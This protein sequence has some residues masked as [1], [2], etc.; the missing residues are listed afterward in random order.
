MSADT[1]SG[2][3]LCGAVRFRFTGAP[4]WVLHCHCESCRKATSSPMTTWVSILDGNLTWAQGTPAVYESSPGAQR[5]FCRTCG[6]PMSFVHDRFPG[7]THL[8]AAS[9][10]TPDAVQ[11]S[12][13]VFFA[14]RLAWSDLHDS[15][16]RFNGTSGRGKTPDRTGP[17]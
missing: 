7:E 11:P 3:C 12:R 17:A 9:L 4:K 13:H 8:Y 5:T 14:E 16:P 1:L 2:G 10:D 15:L 6:S